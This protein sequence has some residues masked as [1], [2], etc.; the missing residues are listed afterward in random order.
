L[1]LLVLA[2]AGIAAGG[3]LAGRLLAEPES[4]GSSSRPGASGLGAQQGLAELLLRSGRVSARTEP[5]VIEDGDLNAFLA[6]HFHA[7][8]LT[9]EP[10]YVRAGA[11]WLEVTGRTSARRVTASTGSTVWQILPGAL[12]DLEVWLSA[13][14]RLTVVGGAAEVTIDRVVIGRQSVPPSWLWGLTGLDPRELLAWRI[15]PVVERIAIEPGRV[16]IHTRPG[17]G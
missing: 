7:R 1:S 10:L 17:R 16:V 3:V 12:L 5:I 2:A 11:G 9:L 6:R 15:P 4:I 8:R 13:R 14:G